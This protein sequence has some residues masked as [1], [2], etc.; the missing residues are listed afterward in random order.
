VIAVER[1]RKNSFGMA[2]HHKNQ[3]KE[4]KTL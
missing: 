3:N 2:N 4:E 1:E